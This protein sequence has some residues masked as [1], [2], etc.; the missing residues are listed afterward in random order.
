LE[1]RDAVES[2]GGVG[3]FVDELDLGGSLGLVFVLELRAVELVGGR[4]LGRQNGGLA[5]EAVGERVERGAALAGFGARASGM[6]GIGAVSGGAARSE[7][8]V[9]RLVGMEWSS[10]FQIAR[11]GTAERAEFGKLLRSGG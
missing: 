1:Q 6:D 5:G 4:V 11:G 8:G 10:R 2:P 3:A 7:N 9:G